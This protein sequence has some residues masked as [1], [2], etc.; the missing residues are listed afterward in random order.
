MSKIMRAAVKFCGGCDPTFDR[1]EYVERIKDTAGKRVSWIGL[2]Q[3]RGDVTL[4]VCG[5][6]KACPVDEM[7]DIASS[8]VITHNE[9]SPEIVVERILRKGQT[10]ED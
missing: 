1:V 7:Q 3:D 4:V 5:C 2:Y 6:P 9:L 10:H 8:V